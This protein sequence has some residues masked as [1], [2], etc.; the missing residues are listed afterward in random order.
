ML[1]Q[2]LSLRKHT[3]VGQPGGL[4]LFH[5][6]G[7]AGGRTLGASTHTNSAAGHGYNGVTWINVFHALRLSYMA[8]VIGTPAWQPQVTLKCDCEELWPRCE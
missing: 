6:P 4:A 8:A 1:S 2:E 5:F 7:C 3:R